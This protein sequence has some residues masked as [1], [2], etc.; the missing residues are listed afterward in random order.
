M[1]P[2]YRIYP[3]KDSI[4]VD[5]WA[6]FTEYGRNL[7][8]IYNR[9]ELLR[10][11]RKDA[12]AKSL[13]KEGEELCFVPVEPEERMPETLFPFFKKFFPQ[14]LLKEKFG[15]KN[16]DILNVELDGVGL[17]SSEIKR[18]KNKYKL[19]ASKPKPTIIERIKEQ[20]KQVFNH[21]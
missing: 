15:A 3:Q 4:V 18:L 21:D 5:S 13:L 7:K 17:K 10:G 1:S 20:A 19:K 6:G 14:L 11:L 12:D 16:P 9:E 2:K 8:E